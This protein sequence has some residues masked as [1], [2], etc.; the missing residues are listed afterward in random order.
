MENYLIKNITVVNEGI[1]QVKDVLIKNG[2]IE[3]IADSIDES[4]SVIEINGEGK[5][6]LPGA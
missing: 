2:R 3:K 6:L 5:H 1:L 4:L